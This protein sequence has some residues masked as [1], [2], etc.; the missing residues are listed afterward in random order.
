[1]DDKKP[2]NMD[3]FEEEIAEGEFKD[4][5]P[6]FDDEI[7]YL[8]EE[9]GKKKGLMAKLNEM[10]GLSI[11]WLG[12]LL[13]VLIVLFLL[14][15]KGSQKMDNEEFIILKSRVED[16]ESRQ[17]QAALPEIYEQKLD[18]MEADILKGVQVSDRL[19]QLEALLASK[20][21]ALEKDIQDLKKQL[22]E[23]QKMAAAKTVAK[24]A[25]REPKKTTKPDSVTYHVV[26]KGENIYRIGLKYNLTE[27]EVRELNN[28]TKDSFI[29]PGQK[30]KVSK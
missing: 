16:L 29:Y 23:T 3:E 26:K 28:L 24:P 12:I 15:P 6:H 10:P 18:K 20:I 30:L 19:D 22:A 8:N 14:L 2:D 5:M 13:I 7:E 4:P 21:D 25:T 17:H 9:S 1:M 27:A 11:G